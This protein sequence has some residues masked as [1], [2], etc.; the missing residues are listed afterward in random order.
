MLEEREREEAVDALQRFGEAAH[1]E[2]PDDLVARDERAEPEVRCGRERDGHLLSRHPL[3]GEPGAVRLAADCV[4]QRGGKQRQAD[5]RVEHE[6]R[7]ARP[8]DDDGHGDEVVEVL[9][10]TSPARGDVIGATARGFARR[11]S[12]LGAG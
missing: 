12:N 1:V 10:G 9:E 8:V 11:R 7:P 6:P 4:G 2:D 3:P 5:A